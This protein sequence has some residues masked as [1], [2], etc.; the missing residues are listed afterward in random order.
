MNDKPAGKPAPAH[1]QWDTKVLLGVIAIVTG[2]VQ[3]IGK[4]VESVTAHSQ[5]AAALVDHATKIIGN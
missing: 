4:L 1:Q 2:L 3:V 5:P